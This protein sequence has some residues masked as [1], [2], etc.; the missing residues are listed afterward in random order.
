MSKVYIVHLRAYGFLHPGRE[1]LGTRVIKRCWPVI[2]GS[3][4][5]GAVAAGLIRLS[6][7]QQG[8]EPE[9]RCKDSQCRRPC[10]YRNLIDL[11][12]SNGHRLRFSPLVPSTAKLETAVDYCAAAAKQE[13]HTFTTPHAP[14]NRQAMTIHGNQ[15]YGVV[16]H[17]PFQEYRGFIVE[18]HPAEAHSFMPQIR[19]SL[20]MLPFLPFGGW[21]KFCPV[22]AW[23]AKGPIDDGTFTEGLAEVVERNGRWLSLLTPS[24]MQDSGNWLM[25]S[26]AEMRVTRLRRYRAWRVGVYAEHGEDAIYRAE[27]GEQTPPVLGLPEGSRFQ[28]REEPQLL[29]ELGDQFLWGVGNTNWTYL[30]WGQVIVDGKT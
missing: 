5:Y 23:L 7:D 24:P 2:P 20:R 28:L 30:G 1:R 13:G 9:T 21:G 17:E 29:D 26:A 18:E 12:K 15:L 4:L 25:T 3:T 10:E 11:V 22:E 14:I 27:G 19:K 16:G 8:P 6:C